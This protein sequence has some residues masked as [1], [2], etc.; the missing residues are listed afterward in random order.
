MKLTDSP[1]TPTSLTAQFRSCFRER[2]REKQRG[3]VEKDVRVGKRE[4]ER[5][6]ERERS[7]EIGSVCGS[8]YF[9]FLGW[10]HNYVLG[11]KRAEWDISSLLGD[12]KWVIEWWVIGDKWWV[13][14]DHFFSPKQPLNIG[15]VTNRC[16]SS[17]KLHSHSFFHSNVAFFWVSYVKGAIMW[18]NSSTS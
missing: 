18:E 11:A 16:F 8:Q 15:V 1:L 3:E 12:R 4:R 5:E 2:R 7:S 14:S 6:R 10:K 13:M 9:S 17:Q